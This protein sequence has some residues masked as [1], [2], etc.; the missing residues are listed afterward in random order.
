[1]TEY[2]KGLVKMHDKNGNMMLE[3]DERKELRGRA[4]E[5]DLNKDGVI[6]IDELVAHL[7]SN[8]SAPATAAPG[9]AT[10][11][12][13]AT[14]A[15]SGNSPSNSSRR[16][17]DDRK[18]VGADGIQRVFYGTAGGATADPKEGDK[19]HTYRFRGAGERLPASLPG[20]FKSK[21]ANGD[22]QVSMCEYSRSW[23]K[24]TVAEFKRYVL[25]D[26]GI[27]TSKEA[28]KPGKSGS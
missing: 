5:A 12:A 2:A 6:T 27:V 17:G 1:M 28:S 4:A 7:S 24:S 14:P 8:S 15:S 16:D 20:W 13:S 3:A 10:S 22:G 18:Q 11:A 9:S 25:N 23:S 26:D 19:R 21:D